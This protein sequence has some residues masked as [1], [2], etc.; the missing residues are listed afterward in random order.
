MKPHLLHPE[1]DFAIQAGRPAGTEALV[2]DL[3]LTQ[4]FDGMAQGDEFVADVVSKVI[5]A[6]T[7]GDLETIRY[8][9]DVLRDCLVNPAAV[10]QLYALAQE[11]IA[12]EQKLHFGLLSRTPDTVLR[13]ALEVLY[14]LLAAL[15]SLQ[16]FAAGQAGNFTSAGFRTLLAAIE[17]ELD[18]SYLEG[19]RGQL[20]E[21]EFAGGLL[22]SAALGAGNKGTDYTLRKLPPKRP[23]L[24]GRLFGAKAPVYAITI[25]EQDRAGA[26]ALWELK[27]RGINLAANALG[28][29]ADHLLH[30]F[31]LLRAELAFYAGC[32]NLHERLVRKGEPACFPVPLA[33]GERRHMARGLYDISLSLLLPDRVVGNDLQGDGKELFVITGA[34]QGGKSTFLRSIGQA[35]L[36]MQAGMF[37]G[38][39]SFTANLC[40]GLFTHYRR[41]EDAG[42]AS[43]KLDEE[44]GRM[45]AIVDRIAPNSMLLCNESFAATNEREGSEIARQIVTALVQR[46]VKLFFVT[47]LNEFA[48][49]LHTQGHAN[50]HFL[51]AGRAEDGAR[52]FVLCAG[53]PLQTS[54]GAD[55]YEQIF[56]P[57]P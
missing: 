39:E 46:R 18:A 6:A 23:G 2:Q 20:R 56:G 25:A 30:F 24:A 52:T 4:L 38:A 1:Q 13:R 32:L 49:G 44:L 7:A 47:H 54:F 19:V 33:A 8:R 48:H 15:A 21:L 34:N 26:R 55:L 37:V 5:L 29:A 35:Q 12:S 51:R 43:G 3:G 16:Q 31:D 27:E 22:V 53:A 57:T 17:R 14:A 10:R 28:Q 41:E 50:I 36:M 45:S 40:S 11:A 42:L 9:Q